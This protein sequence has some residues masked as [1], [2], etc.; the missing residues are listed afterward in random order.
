MDL[1]GTE[2]KPNESTLSAKQKDLEPQIYLST[3]GGTFGDIE[4]NRPGDETPEA[5][6]A[7]TLQAMMTMAR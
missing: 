6:P 7:E 4:R 1:K 2:Q 5:G 3:N